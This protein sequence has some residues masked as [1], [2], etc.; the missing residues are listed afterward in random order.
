[1]DF[2][3]RL[4]FGYFKAGSSIDFNASEGI[5]LFRASDPI[6]QGLQIF[7]LER[8]SSNALIKFDRMPESFLRLFEPARDSRVA[9]KIELKHGIVVMQFAAPRVLE[10]TESVY[11]SQVF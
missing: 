4:T 3:A 5:G 1:M 8:Q 10:P 11:L 7:I 6:P 9:R 2:F